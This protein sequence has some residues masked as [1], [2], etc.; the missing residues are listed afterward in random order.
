MRFS[1]APIAILL[2]LAVF[3]PPAEP[4]V[5]LKKIAILPFE[6]LT[7]QDL[8]AEINKL[9]SSHLQKRGYNV[10]SSELVDDFLLSTR[11]R[12]IRLADKSIMR[13]LGETLGSDV[14]I[15]GAVNMIKEENTPQIDISAQML[16][17]KDSSVVWATSVFLSGD[18]F[19]GLLGI[20]KINTMDELAPRAVERLFSNM[21]DVVE[22]KIDTTTKA[23]NSLMSPFEIVHASLYPAR[24]KEGTQVTLVVEIREIEGK[25]KYITGVLNNQDISL[26]T[27]GDRWF[28]GS[29]LA[30]GI[31]G[32]Y[33]LSLYAIGN[34][35]KVFFFEELTR[36]VVDNTP[37]AIALKATP[38]LISPNSDGIND[39]ANLFL[40]LES[41]DKLKSWKIEISDQ[42]GKV[43][44]SSGGEGELPKSLVWHG[45]DNS[46][47]TLKDG[48][49]IARVIV[50]DEAGHISSSEGVDI[51]VDAIPPQVKLQ[52]D[53]IEKDIIELK[54][55]TKDIADLAS[56][57]ISIY[58]A[59]EKSLAR[60]DGTSEIPAT[61]HCTAPE[62]MLT[63]KQYTLMY[64]LEI[65]DV[66]GN[67]FSTERQKIEIVPSSDKG[68]GETKKGA[69]VS[70][71]VEDF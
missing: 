53:K 55:E 51:S 50:E 24:V 10:I 41:S 3:L 29:F 28:R 8:H 64:T 60:F 69:T 25:P 7:G 43:V 42:E 39:S 27:E 62:K 59:E 68:G 57:N 33:P 47:Q 6:N 15:M 32:V 20:G 2:L 11:V 61:L 65:R 66:A 56:W 38:G 22:E 21:P 12:R 16:N 70:P 49:Y 36:L 71:W 48:A 45:E 67:T 1:I 31:E 34:V 13:K 54:V 18:D 35:N 17:A 19:A 40:S 63:N 4:S 5:S 9:V 46:G 14:I 58:D 37:P 30:P 23:E 52:F 26:A 44:R